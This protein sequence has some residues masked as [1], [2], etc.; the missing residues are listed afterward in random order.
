VTGGDQS[1]GPDRLRRLLGGPDTAW[2]LTRARRR[3]E[4]GTP[5]TGVVTLTNSTPSQRHAIEVL[6]GRRP[7][8]GASLTVSLD[9]VDRILRGS[10]ACPG[11]LGTAVALLD[12]PIRDLRR[13]S[14][15]TAAAWRTAHARFDAAVSGRDELTG[16][17]A[18]LDATGLIRR[19]SGGPDEA[20]ILLDRLAAILDRLPSPGIPLGQLAAE[21][22][23]DAHALD[24][25]SP[26][27]T[28]ALSAARALNG[29]R[30]RAEGTAEA[31]RATWAAVGVH[32]DELS[33]VVLCSG[34]RGN[35]TPLGRMLAA[36]HES[37]E[38]V[39]LTLRQLRHHAGSM[40]VRGLVRICENPVVV[41]AAADTLGDRCPPLVCAGG[42]PSAAV[43]RLLEILAEGGAEFAYHGD[44][45]WGGIGIAAAIYHRIGWHPWRYDA[46]A[47]LAA[48]STAP[49]TG[50]PCPA[51]WDPGLTAAMTERA[52]R[53]EEELVLT[54]LLNDLE[55]S[56]A[57][58]ANSSREIIKSRH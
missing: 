16:W 5:L 17:R 26:L 53:V 9:E 21:T 22:C 29:I 3:L 56:A 30:Y 20:R 6:L 33:S 10:G 4:R 36:A 2:L 54:D 34:L 55:G 27:A 39:T 50:R 31:R 52:V 14:A 35:D 44:F 28:L 19:L 25:G 15:E 12:G 47:Y 45:D 42:R 1:A 49:L 7:G 8:S 38:P 32:L 40:A 18:W 51:P 11:G 58:A 43:W 48:T 41:A 46:T 57:D 24:E 23:T 37:G 13:E